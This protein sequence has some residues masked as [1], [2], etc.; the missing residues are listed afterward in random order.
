MKIEGFKKINTHNFTYTQQ[1]EKQMFIVDFYVRTFIL[2]RVFLTG[3]KIIEP[4]F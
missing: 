2:Y 3:T 4:L 1:Y